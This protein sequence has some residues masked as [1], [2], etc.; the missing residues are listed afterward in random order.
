MAKEK[1]YSWME[2]TYPGPRKLHYSETTNPRTKPKRER[3]SI[4]EVI[5]EKNRRTRKTG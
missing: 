3:G 2:K 5:R 1:D 4:D